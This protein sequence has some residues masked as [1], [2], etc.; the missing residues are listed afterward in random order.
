MDEA[1]FMFTVCTLSA[2]ADRDLPLPPNRYEHPYLG[3][4][5]ETL[6]SEIRKQIGEWNIYHAVKAIDNLL[7]HL[8]NIDTIR[9]IVVQR[10]KRRVVL[11]KEYLTTDREDTICFMEKMGKCKDLTDRLE[12]RL[13]DDLLFSTTQIPFYPRHGT[14]VMPTVAGVFTALFDFENGG[15]S[16]SLGFF[17]NDDQVRTVYSTPLVHVRHYVSLDPYTIVHLAQKKYPLLIGTPA[18]NYNGENN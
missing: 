3:Q 4:V 6:E 11:P 2:D 18:A 12:Q 10:C 1:N 16:R 15:F 17:Q 13:G 14:L 7:M 5:F 8:Q 9:G